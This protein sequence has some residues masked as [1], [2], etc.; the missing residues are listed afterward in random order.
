[1]TLSKNQIIIVHSSQLLKH[2]CFLIPSLYGNVGM[3]L[4]YS[5]LAKIILFSGERYMTANIHGLLHLPNS[6]RKLGP[7]WVHS[8]FPFEAA[9]GVILK[10]FHGTQNTEK[11]V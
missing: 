8:C 3:A 1:M 11:Q 10:L 6:V 4:F 2:Y 7:L 9:N 5:Y